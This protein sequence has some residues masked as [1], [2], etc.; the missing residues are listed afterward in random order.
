MKG[1]TS[2]RILRI[3]ITILALADGVL[4]L[5]LDFV[6]FG[7]R[8]GPPSGPRPTPPPGSPPPAPRLA[9]PLPL[10]VLFLLNFIG[11]VVLVV[12]FWLSPR[13]LGRRRWL[14][15]VIMIIYAAITFI[16]WVMFGAPNPMGLGYLSKGLEIALIIALLVDIWLMRKQ[17]SVS[18][19][20]PA[21]SS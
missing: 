3:V 1:Q 20:V 7:G 18:G 5:A 11:E 9:L 12:L 13:L 6:L 21:K 17:P 14:I 8:N 10:N 19:E 2:N 15:N 4:H 16:A